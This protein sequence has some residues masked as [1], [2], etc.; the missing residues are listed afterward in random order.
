MK[1]SNE[2]FFVAPVSIESSIIL[3]LVTK[4]QQFL[5]LKDD[6]LSRRFQA[7]MIK[8]QSEA[9]VLGNNNKKF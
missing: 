8:P 2:D 7:N 4:I 5:I 9:G 1:S 6:N 3:T